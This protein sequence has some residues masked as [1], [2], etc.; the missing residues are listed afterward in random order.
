MGDQF[1]KDKIPQLLKRLER[2]NKQEKKV[3]F[4]KVVQVTQESLF[5]YSL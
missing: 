3:A 1:E 4:E 5:K 2:G